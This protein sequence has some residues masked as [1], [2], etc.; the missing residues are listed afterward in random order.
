MAVAELINCLLNKLVIALILE[1]EINAPRSNDVNKDTKKN[2][3]RW[4][5]RIS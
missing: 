2:R 3:N 1:R 5:V 4:N